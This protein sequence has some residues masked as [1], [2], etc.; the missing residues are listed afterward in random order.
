[1]ALIAHVDPSGIGIYDAQAG[2]AGT[3]PPAEFSPL[4]T[5]ESVTA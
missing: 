2:I 4:L 3:D 5:V 1:M